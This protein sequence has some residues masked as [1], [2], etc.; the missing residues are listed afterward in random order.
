[1]NLLRA[2][3]TIGGWTLLSRL[4][5]FA[6][7]MLIA[8]FLGAGP[9]ADAF[10]VAF[11][12]PNF[13]RR[14]FGEGAF[15]SA[16][17]PLFARK[18]TEA[19]PEAAASFARDALGALLM[20]LI[21]LTLLAELFM[22]ALLL[23]FAPGFAAD[24]DKFALA[25][26]LTR[27]TFPYLLCMSLLALMSGVLNSLDRFAAAAAAPILLNLTLILALLALT[28]LLP[29]AAH[30]L[31]IGVAFAGV[32]QV[33]WLALECR[34]AGMALVPARPRASPEIR[35]LARLMLPGTLGAGVV[36][37]NLMVDTILASLL[38]TGAVSFLYYADRVN[39]LP[40]GVVGVAIGV[41]LLPALTKSLRSGAAAEAAAA[42]NRALEF[43]L[44]LTLPAAAALLSVPGPIVAVLF[45]RGAFGTADSGATA[46]ALAAFAVGL[47]AY[48]LIKVFA[49]GFYA[50][51]DTATPVKVAVAAMVI[52]IAFALA[53]MPLWAHIG[54]AL[55]TALAAWINAATLGLLLLRRGF[56]R[57]DAQLKRR[58]PRIVLCSALLAVALW[59]GAQ[60]LA[61][62][63][64]GTL[65]IRAGALALLVGGG[66]LL[67]AVLAQATG[68]A[69]ISDLRRG[70]RRGAA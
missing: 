58:V 68:A 40:L 42:Q 60:A 52:N 53:L 56:W 32:L 46:G 3:T 28:P 7:D 62:A 23:A 25:V 44:L 59:F 54:I 64:H 16:F 33:A 34:R 11:K 70:F 10:F 26:L 47:P 22:P 13:F 48:V 43:T 2:V 51:E 67:F 27:I 12:L 24:T 55:A 1:M 45:E 36:Q 50:R 30:A 6:R 38:P 20:V 4:T 14:L 65:E 37:I 5:G 49:P 35:K 57:P 63:F 29:S 31:A 39:Q 17:L 15:N 8:S 21:P 69:A 19:G 41:A 9:A 66:G 61:D 18:L